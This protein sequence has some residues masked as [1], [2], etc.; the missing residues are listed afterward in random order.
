MLDR[1]FAV[2]G[3][4]VT[5]IRFSMDRGFVE[6]LVEPVQDMICHRCDSKLGPCRSK[7]RMKVRDMPV[8][9]YQN[10]VIFYRRKGFCTECNK[11][12]S[13]KIAFVSEQSP[14]L[15]AQYVWWLGCLTEMA[16]VTNAA[17]LT[18][19]DPMTL[20]RI[21][22]DRLKRMLQRY[23]I[24][25]P[26]M[27]AVDEVYARKKPRDGE[28]RND[29]FFTIITD[30]RTR[31]VIWVAES[32]NETALDE[33]FKIL[34][35][36][37]CKKIKVVAI[38]QHAGYFRSAVKHCRNATLVWDKFH[39][40]QK[41]MEAVNDSRK[42]LVNLMPKAQKS[43]LLSGKYRFIFL[44]RAS[45]R[46]SEESRHIDQV[47]K[48]N[49]IFAKLEIIKERML[50]FFDAENAEAGLKIFHEIG[51]WI[52]TLGIP[53]LKKWFKN[54]RAGWDTLKNY[55]QFRIT[56]ALAE[57]INNVIKSLKRSRFGFRNMEY[58]KLKILQICGYL[59]SKH[60]G[61]LMFPG[62]RAEPTF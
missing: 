21:D 2:Y 13:E 45:K 29:R 8:M 35:K 47:T 11:I 10:W 7:H 42:Y 20:W 58:F 54:L 15:S 1:I 49:E 60:M 62:H 44:K 53:P 41:F 25:D 28:T 37:R 43:K 59:N 14:H 50:T 17:N 16:P 36:D 31:K 32:R 27:I 51:Q 38:D 30:L 57:G 56:N 55:F 46:T 61:T 39:I 5:D 22:F 24:P 4:K 6:T 9:T 33:F 12:R 52:W 23:E 34:G 48:E 40:M 18:D 19:I 3:F 26:T